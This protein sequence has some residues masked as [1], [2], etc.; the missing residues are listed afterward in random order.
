MTRKKAGWVLVSSSAP[1]LA[2]RLCLTEYF[3]PCFFFFF[4]PDGS[5]AVVLPCGGGQLSTAYV[6]A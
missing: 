5:E 1:P 3:M 2:C 6:F 4:P